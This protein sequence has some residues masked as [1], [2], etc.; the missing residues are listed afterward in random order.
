[1]RLHT[2]GLI[3][4]LAFSLL[5]LPLVA[6]TQPRVKVPRIGY[7]SDTPGPYAEAFR[8]GLREHGYIEGEN[9]TV[10]YRWA[11]GRYDRL[12][13]LAA[14]LV[15]LKVD[16]LVPPNRAMPPSRRPARFLL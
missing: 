3:V 15:Q 5:T 2:V 1:M 14:E 16:I 11:E 9:I 8:Q 12:P 10:E 6:E 7:I 4:I 13:A